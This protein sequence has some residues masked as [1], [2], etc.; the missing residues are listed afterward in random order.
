MKPNFK[1][2]VYLILLVAVLGF[3]EAGY[4]QVKASYAQKLLQDAWQESRVTGNNIK[5]WSWADS[6]PVFKLQWI[7][8]TQ[9]DARSDE[10][11]NTGNLNHRQATQN[12]RGHEV[13]SSLASVKAEYLV[14]ADSS[15]ESLAFGPGLHTPDIFPGDM[16]NSI[17][18][19]HRDTHFKELQDIQVN[20]LIRIE[21]KHG[22]LRQFQVDQIKVV[23]AEVEAPIVGIAERRLTLVTC[24]PFDSSG[25]ETS[26]RYLV[27]AILINGNN[28]A[29][30]NSKIERNNKAS[31]HAGLKKTLE[32]RIPGVLISPNQESAHPTQ[33]AY[34]F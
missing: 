7:S 14:L 18:A 31:N 34:H 15:G 27:S 21:L 10:S 13:D 16:G 19:A 5:P 32:T 2:F 12:S 8:A 28:K 20:D 1:K 17:I 24:Y 29:N 23:D 26:L 6:W 4:Y 22:E 25:E 9:K 11:L 3:L 33:L 30:R